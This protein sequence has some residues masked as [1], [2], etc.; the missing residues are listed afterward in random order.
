[1]L[2]VGFIGLGVMGGGMAGTL[3]EAGY[4]LTV[5]S[6]NPKAAEPL[7]RRGARDKSL[8]P[9]VRRRLATAGEGLA[10]SAGRRQVRQAMAALEYAGGAEARALLR[11]LAGGDPDAWLTAEARAALRRVGRPRPE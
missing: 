11:E 4:D 6:R 2:K 1:M 8:S 5:W 10:G 9:E 3:V 7:V